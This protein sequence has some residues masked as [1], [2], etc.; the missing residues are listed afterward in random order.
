MLNKENKGQMMAYCAWNR[1][2]FFFLKMSTNV[3]S[4]VAVRTKLPSV[5]T[6]LVHSLVLVQ[7][8]TIQTMRDAV[9]VC[10]NFFTLINFTVHPLSMSPS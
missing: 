1:D 8:A 10:V 3:K 2:A 9:Q 4:P 7:K 6:L 5:L